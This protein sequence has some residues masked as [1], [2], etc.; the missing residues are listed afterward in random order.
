[1]ELLDKVKKALRV[2]HAAL[3]EAEITPLIEAAKAELVIAGVVT[4]KDDDPMI[5]RYVTAYVKAHFGY[6]NPE[7]ERFERIADSIKNLLT[8]VRAYNGGGD[9]SGTPPSGGGLAGADKEAI[10]EAVQEYFEGGDLALS[11]GTASKNGG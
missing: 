11:G 2:N 8:Q 9:Y 4:V 7:A 3:D 1:V 10:A 6:D 5:C